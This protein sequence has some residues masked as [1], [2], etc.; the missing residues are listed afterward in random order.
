MG[1]IA[2]IKNHKNT[3]CLKI[4]SIVK[5]KRFGIERAISAFNYLLRKSL[6]LK[7]YSDRV[8]L[9]GKERSEKFVYL[10]A[11]NVEFKKRVS[12]KLEKRDS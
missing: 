11:E 10:I 3:K 1:L 7:R 9:S 2:D 12:K 4:N 6:D 5:V 8:M